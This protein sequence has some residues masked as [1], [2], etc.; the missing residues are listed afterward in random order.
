MAFYRA[1]FWRLPIQNRDFPSS[2]K[3]TISQ[4]HQWHQGYV[5]AAFPV[6]SAQRETRARVCTE[7]WGAKADAAWIRCCPPLISLLITITQKSNQ[8]SIL[9]LCG[10]L[11]GLDLSSRRN[12]FHWFSHRYQS[13]LHSYS[14]FCISKVF[15]WAGVYFAIQSWFRFFRWIHSLMNQIVLTNSMVE[16]L[17]LSFTWIYLSS[18]SS[19]KISLCYCQW[20]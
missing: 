15:S 12:C 3:T 9:F 17:C 4:R 7:G 2:K 18:A 20:D 8:I 6:P 11:C 13:L 16:N 10:F 1:F 19:Y 5:Q 14:N